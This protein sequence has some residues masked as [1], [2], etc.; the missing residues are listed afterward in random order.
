MNNTRASRHHMVRQTLLSALILLS[1]AFA[2]TTRAEDPK[3]EPLFNGK[4]L[5]G[6]K[7]PNPNPWWS[8]VDGVLVGQ[9]DPSK[10]G[11][12]LYTEKTY[13]DCVIE[14]D[15]RFPD[16]ID[17]GIMLR[18]PTLQVQLGVSRSLKVDMTGS[19]Y[20]KR[21]SDARAGYIGK[22][23]G[24]DKLL[25]LNDWNHLKIEAKGNVFKTYLNGQHVLTFEA[26]D[27]KDAGPIGLQI[28]AGVEMKVEF[29][30][31]TVAEL[32]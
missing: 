19:I 29:K 12:D 23:Q 4:D 8:V 28:H 24:V 15:V 7:V 10:K 17:S 13:K 22:A 18:K 21:K 25:K 6:W 30:N 20:A 14:C 32:K 9:S 31:L 5:T 3:P 16:N 26:E 11:S 1:F 27:F 2:L